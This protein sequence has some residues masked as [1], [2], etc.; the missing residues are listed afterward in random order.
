MLNY[1]DNVQYR[2]NTQLNAGHKTEQIQ[3]II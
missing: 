2:S 3:M 1:A